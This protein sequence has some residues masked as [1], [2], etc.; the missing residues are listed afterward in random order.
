MSKYL[1]P[2][3]LA[4]ELKE[5][6]RRLH[7]LETSPQSQQTSITAGAFKVRDETGALVASLGLQDDGE[8]GLTFFDASGNEVVRLGQLGAGAHGFRIRDV[9]SGADIFAVNEDDGQ[10]APWPLFNWVQNPG[11]LIDANG[12]ATT[13]SATYD[14]MYRSNSV[15]TNSDFVHGTFLIVAGASTVSYKVTAMEVDETTNIGPETD[16]IEVTGLTG[17]VTPTF[18]FAIPTAAMANPATGVRGKRVN[19]NFYVKRTAGATTIS[20]APLVNGRLMTS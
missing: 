1:G 2:D 16:C 3:D 13:T 7:I 9:L 10:T 4:D 14:A 5:L 15:S 18:D 12:R 6:R 19:L 11:V 20:V 8:Y 17:T